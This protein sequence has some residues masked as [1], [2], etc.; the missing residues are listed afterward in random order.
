MVCSWHCIQMDWEKDMDSNQDMVKGKSLRQQ[1]PSANNWLQQLESIRNFE[2]MKQFHGSGFPWEPAVF[3]AF[4]Q[5]IHIIGETRPHLKTRKQGKATKRYGCYKLN[6]ILPSSK[7]VLEC[8]NFR[9]VAPTVSNPV[10]I[11]TL[12]YK[13]MSVLHWGGKFYWMGT[14]HAIVKG[15]LSSQ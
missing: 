11:S 15:F 5:I 9:K 10:D 12:A 3:P 1:C 14:L 8:S 4:E 7:V 13:Y 6:L 2:R